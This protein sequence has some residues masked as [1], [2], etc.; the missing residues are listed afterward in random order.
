MA[1]ATQITDEQHAMLLQAS[2]DFAFQQLAEAGGFLPFATQARLDGEMEYV[3]LGDESTREAV[4]AIFDRLRQTMAER[5]RRGEVIAVATVTNMSLEDSGV[6]AP[7][8]FDRAIRVHVES[9][10]FSR[11]VIAP[12]RIDEAD[13]NS[14]KPYLI[15]GEMMAFETAPDIFAS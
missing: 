7:P 11:I 8:E 12:Y 9:P 2:R 10:G 15:D 13:E 6:E 4:S 14:E 5:A 1:E 3:R